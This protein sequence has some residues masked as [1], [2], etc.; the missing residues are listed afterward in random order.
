MFATNGERMTLN[1]YHCTIRGVHIK[2]RNALILSGLGSRLQPTRLRRVVHVA[3][4]TA[5]A[6]ISLIECK[7]KAS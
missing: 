5:L 6:P 3:L 4:P 2:E 7:L 1:R